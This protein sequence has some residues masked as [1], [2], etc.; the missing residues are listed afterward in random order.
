MY[1]ETARM[2][3]AAGPV[4]TIEVAIKH[5]ARMLDQDPRSAAEQAREILKTSPAHPMGEF[6]LAAAER[7]LGRHASAIAR[8]QQ[9]LQKHPMWAAALVE[10]AA[11]QDAL[12]L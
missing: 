8:I 11:A 9:L 4:G 6:L 7:R 5:A 12:G 10:L 2:N 1:A 3:S